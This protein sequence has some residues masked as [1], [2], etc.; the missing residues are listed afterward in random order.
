MPTEDCFQS[1]PMPFPAWLVGTPAEPP[2]QVGVP[3]PGTRASSQPARQSKSPRIPTEGHGRHPHPKLGEKIS[4]LWWHT[5]L[6]ER[7]QAEDERHLVGRSAKYRGRLQHRLPNAPQEPNLEVS[8]SL[9]TWFT[10]YTKESYLLA[11]R[12]LASGATAAG[13]GTEA[14]AGSI[15]PHLN[16]SE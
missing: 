4:A 2:T 15:V 13:E 11:R 5:Q 3:S 9:R 6:L 16:Y 8:M 10:R 12:R 1:P 7:L 14:P